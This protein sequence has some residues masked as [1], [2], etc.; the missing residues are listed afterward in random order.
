[1]FL[2]YLSIYDAVGEKKDP[3]TQ[4]AVRF[5]LNGVISHITIDRNITLEGL[6]EKIRKDFSLDYNTS[7]YNP[8]K[9]YFKYRSG[10]F[11]VQLSNS[12]AIKDSFDHFEKSKSSPKFELYLDIN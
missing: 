8:S 4:I 11:W 12:L 5:H 7:E 1:M 10:D 3:R 2:L 9:H 6:I